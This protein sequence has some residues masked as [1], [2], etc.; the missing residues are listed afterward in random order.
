[1]R[2][3]AFSPPNTVH[4]HGVDDV[5]SESK[6]IACFASCTPHV[7]FFLGVQE[8]AYIEVNCMPFVHQN[9]LIISENA[10]ASARR[11]TNLAV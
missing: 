1:M 7:G 8:V 3:I 6:T 11:A 10:W 4:K 5:A 9:R 2:R